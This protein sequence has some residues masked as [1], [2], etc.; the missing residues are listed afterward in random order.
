MKIPAEGLHVYFSVYLILWELPVEVEQHWR[1]LGWCCIYPHFLTCL[2]AKDVVRWK[3]Q[4]FEWLGDIWLLQNAEK[5]NREAGFYFLRCDFF[6]LFFCVLQ[7][8]PR[9][10]RGS[11]PKRHLLKTN[12]EYDSLEAILLKGIHEHMLSG[13]GFHTCTS[14]GI[15]WT[16]EN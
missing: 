16:E 13:Q 7:E 9:V 2:I 12:N 6:F 5:R 3:L 10:E 15:F 11:T 4:M 1:Q 8:P 14:R